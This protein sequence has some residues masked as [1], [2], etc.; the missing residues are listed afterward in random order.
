MPPYASLQKSSLKDTEVR[1]NEE[2]TPWPHL[3]AGFHGDCRWAG[4]WLH[5]GPF[6]QPALRL[7][8]ARR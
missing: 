7:Q 1:R 6:E 2:P 5:A 4:F 3:D 8:I